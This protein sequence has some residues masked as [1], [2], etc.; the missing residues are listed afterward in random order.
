MVSPPRRMVDEELELGDVTCLDPDSSAGQ[1]G[2]TLR[3]SP[4]HPSCLREPSGQLTLTVY[5]VPN[6][7]ITSGREDRVLRKR[8]HEG[9]FGWEAKCSMDA[10]LLQPGH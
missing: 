2:L 1:R 7:L 8:K 3:L 10:P 4:H 9:W 6:E 5:S